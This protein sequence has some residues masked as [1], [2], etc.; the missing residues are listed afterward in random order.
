MKRKPLCCKQ[1]PAIVTHDVT[2]EQMDNLPLLGIGTVNSG[3]SGY[4]NPYNTL[5]TL[6]GVSSYTSSGLFTVNGLGG[7]IPGVPSP[8]L[9]TETMR[10]EGQDATSRIFDTYDYTQM[11][12]P[13]TDAIQEIA[14]QTSNYAP[15]YGAG[16]QRRDQHDDEVRDQSISR[17]RLRLLRQRR[18]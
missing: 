2:L 14:Y 1:K 17:H 9:S 6:P 16:R 4:R 5:L 3:T 18:L 13:N 12:Q 8:P 15:E 10:I 11:A 7:S